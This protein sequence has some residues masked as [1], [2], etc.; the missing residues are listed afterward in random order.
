MR[1]VEFKLASPEKIVEYVYDLKHTLDESKLE[2]RSG[3]GCI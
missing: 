1:K 2:Q 3:L